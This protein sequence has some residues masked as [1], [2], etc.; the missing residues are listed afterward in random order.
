MQDRF[1]GDIGDFGKYGLL[2]ALTG[3][4][5]GAEPR[6]SLGVVWYLNSRKNT[7]Y[8]SKG[9][10]YEKCDPKLFASIAKIIG[11]EQ[12]RETLLNMIDKSR[13]LGDNVAFYQEPIPNK[14]HREQWLRGALVCTEGK[15]VVFLDPDNGISLNEWSVEHVN[16]CEIRPFVKR[17]Q[18][19]IIY[20][21]LSH[22][23]DHPSLIEE[24]GRSLEQKL[25]VKPCVL[26]YRRGTARV[27]FI[28][29]AAEHADA[30]SERLAAFR[31]S[32]WFRNEHFTPLQGE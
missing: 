23:K 1:V 27:Y 9:E 16:I 14:A 6:L 30:I 24:W 31:K 26:W 19:V 20:H 28:L 18:T 21:H 8:L 13:I 15:S 12:E 7:D 4:H 22:Q 17:G 11:R 3:I 32:L 29:P 5:P 25:G 2:R 10:A